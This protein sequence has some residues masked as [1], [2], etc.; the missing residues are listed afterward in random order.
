MTGPYDDILHHPR[1]EPIG[2]QPMSRRTRAA[3][4]AP[5]AAL[6]GFDETI[7]ETARLTR[8]ETFLDEDERE[9]I[10]RQLRFLR[11]H[12]DQAPPVELTYYRPDPLKDGGSYE[13]ILV[14]LRRIDP[15]EQMIELST[16]EL[17]PM[18]H[19]LRLSGDCFAGL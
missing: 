6:P 8:Q 1:P 5:F 19:I 10:D 7:R 4:F 2:R 9:R 11:E 14:T 18:E 17:I 12:L 15:T 16:R 13:T 3:Q